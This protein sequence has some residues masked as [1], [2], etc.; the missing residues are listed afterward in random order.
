MSKV[1]DSISVFFEE[2]KY[3]Y[4]SRDDSLISRFKIKSN[5][6]NITMIVY[7][8][9][10]TYTVSAK[11]PI[12]A[13]EESFSAVSEYLMRA[14]YNMISGCFEMNYN[15]GEIRFKYNQYCKDSLP[16]K[17]SIKRSIMLPLA[18]FNRYGN[19][20]LN[21]MLNGSSP[22]EEIKKAEKDM[23]TEK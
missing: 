7:A 6:S 8:Y 10:D 18:M 2:S 21:V 3:Y 13:N 15:N 22:E 12:F 20:L 1:I 11:C 5:I 9:K 17:D 14:N 16:S 4:E 23:N 19:G